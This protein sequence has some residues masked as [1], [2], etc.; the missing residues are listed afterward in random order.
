MID[1]EVRGVVL[2]QQKAMHYRCS[3]DH[4]KDTGR[5]RGECPNTRVAR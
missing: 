4:E 5:M 1:V 2:R 3:Q